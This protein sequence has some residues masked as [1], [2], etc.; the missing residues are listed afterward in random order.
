MIVLFLI[1]FKLKESADENFKFDEN[2]PEFS[3]TL[4]EKEKLHVTSNFSFSHNVFKRLVLQTCKNKGL[5]EKVSRGYNI[6]RKRKNTG[7]YHFLLLLRCFQKAFILKIAPTR[8][9]W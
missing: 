1:L 7:C 8:D 9:M 5:F 3:K 6:E 4:R 2:D